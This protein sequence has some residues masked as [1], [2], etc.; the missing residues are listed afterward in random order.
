MAGK[1]PFQA[2]DR[3]YA[4]QLDFG[5]ESTPGT[6]PAD[7]AGLAHTH[8]GKLWLDTSVAPPALRLCVVPSANPVYNPAEWFNFGPVPGG[9]TIGSGVYVPLAGSSTIT[10]NLGVTGSMNVA[11]YIYTP[12]ITLTGTTAAIFFEDR[13]NNSVYWAWYAD[14]NSVARLAFSGTGAVLNI[15]TAGDMTLAGNYFYFANS[16][17]N[18]GSSG[19]PFFYGGPNYLIARLGGG[20]GGFVVEGYNATNLLTVDNSGNLT[21]IG[22]LNSG[23][24]TTTGLQVNGNVAVTGT[25]NVAGLTFS[26]SGINTASA[27]ITTTGLQVNGSAAITGTLNVAGMTFSPGG[28]NTAS[29]GITTTG[30]QVNGGGTVTGTFTTTT[31]QVNGGETIT[32][33]LTAT[34]LQLNGSGA[35]TQNLDVQNDVNARGAFRRFP[36]G[37][38][39]KG[40]RMECYG[41]DWDFFSFAESGGAMYFSPDSGTDGFYVIGTNFSDA[42]LKDNIR[43][44]EVDALA[45]ICATPVRAFE[46]NAE[47]RKRMP[48]AEPAVECG[49]VAQELEEV[50]SVGVGVASLANDM[51]HI[52]DQNLTPY[53]FRAIQQLKDEIEELKGRLN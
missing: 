41:G 26:A 44:S 28:I 38:G 36:V 20:I 39:V 11:G 23:G 53:V 9:S 16:T 13:N 50:I 35:I 46:W 21:V 17:G 52:L 6:S 7:V 5:M 47:G 8:L 49:L 30:L 27:G 1:Y 29:A 43:N 33:G 42:R 10:G 31:L 45:M 14:T 3:L 51:R 22:S 12:Q 24:I 18:T 40:A 19:G 15:D 48:Y 37:V 25:L 32:G 4:A 2:Q 34:G